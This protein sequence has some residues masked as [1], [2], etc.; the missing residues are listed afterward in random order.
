MKTN[1]KL[2][3]ISV[4][5]FLILI[6]M[7]LSVSLLITFT[8]Q[9]NNQHD[10]EIFYY[11]NNEQNVLVETSDST[12]F[13]SA[14]EVDQIV[15]TV[16]VLN[17][18]PFQISFADS[19][20]LNATKL[21]VQ[22]IG[23]Q[24]KAAAKKYYSER[25]EAFVSS[26]GVDLESK[27]YEIVLS[28]YS[29]YV[30]IS[31]N[32]FSTFKDYEDDFVT[33]MQNNS[34]IDEIHIMVPEE[35]KEQAT[36]TQNNYIYYME[37]V[38]SDIGADD[39]TYKGNGINVGIIEAE[40]VAYTFSH[41]ELNSLTIH[42]AGDSNSE[43]Q[44]AINVTRLLCGTEGVAK[45]IDAA[46]IF[47]TGSD[48]SFI[49]AFDWLIANDCH[50]INASLGFTKD[51]GKYTWISAFIDYNAKYNRVIFVNSAGNN[52]NESNHYV[53]PPATGYNVIT[54]ANSGLFSDIFYESS[55]GAESSLRMNKP[56]LSAPGTGLMLDRT[57]IGGVGTS[58]SAPIVAGVIAKLLDEFPIFEYFPEAITAILIASA[59]PA[60][61]QGDSWDSNAGAGI[62]NYARARQVA[63]RNLN[64]FFCSTSEAGSVRNSVEFYAE[65][66]RKIRTVA[67]WFANSQTAAWGNS[68]STNIHT[69][70]DLYVRTI[71]N[72]LIKSSMGLTNMEFLIFTNSAA[73]NLKI[74][75]KQYSNKQT[76]DEDIGAV[77]WCYV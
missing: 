70:Y 19:F 21:D 62:V 75:V 8:T 5:S 52:G 38:L 26:I 50:L 51:A 2:L 15:N 27:D 49:S 73:Q 76:S 31:Y 17:Y 25:N 30:Q 68:T 16:Y 18:S 41:S 65:A 12:E 60:L 32:D 23:Q 22:I 33:D 64:V 6:I 13:S 67:L 77:A 24:F 9:T 7:L 42:T 47:H 54:V 59:T 40:G 34:R 10:T 37:D 4:A 66:N 35:F 45:D 53:T 48:K 56:T 58:Y 36:I 11:Y 43:S 61:G 28:D 39:Q 69:D 55:Y 3:N 72:S 57:Y 46:Y 44:H 1:K 63:G 29:P 20:D 14:I 71:D 74:E